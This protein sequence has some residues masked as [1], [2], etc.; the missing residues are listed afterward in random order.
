MADGWRTT[1]DMPEA[2]QKLL[3]QIKDRHRA[4]DQRRRPFIDRCN[5]YYGLYRNYRK[6]LAEPDRDLSEAKRDWGAELF[7]PYCFAT[8]ETI[9][10]RILASNPQMKVKPKD[11]QALS[12]VDSIA[13]LF[14]QRQAEI[15]YAMQLQPVVRSGLKYGLGVGKTMWDR[16]A[17][18]V[19][20]NAP[21]ALGYW[22]GMREVEETVTKSE[23]PT[24]EY[25][26]IFDFFNDPNARDIDTSEFAIHRTWRSTQYVKERIESG[27]WGTAKA[28]D[29]GRATRALIDMEAIEG[30]GSSETRDNVY[31]DRMRAAGLK[32]VTDMGAGK[33]HEVWEYHDRERVVTVLDKTFIVQN[34][35]CYFHAELPFQIFRP[36]PQEG[37]FFGIGEIEPI[38][39][40]Q[41]ELNT[42][43]SQR[44]DNATLILQKAFMYTEGRLVDPNDLTI[45]PG[46][47]IAV[48][49]NP[50]D[51]IAPLDF[52]ELPNSSY[53]EE[54]ALKR[55][56]ERTT[57]VSDSVAGGDSTGSV[58]TAT[59]IQLVQSAAN[60]RIAQKTANLEA[61]L[62]NPAAGQ[63]I[64]LYQQF[65]FGDRTMTVEDAREPSGF[66]FE[67]IGPEQLS[68]RV[69]IVADA[70][71][72]EPEN[73]PQKRN[74]AMI[75]GNQMNGDPDID[76]RK[77]KTWLLGEFGIA[78]PETWLTPL[79]PTLD[80][81]VVGELLVSAGMDQDAALA[82][83]QQALQTSADGVQRPGDGGHPAEQV[84]GETPEQGS[85]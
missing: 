12:S 20:R 13:R 51:V 24:F 10:P 3:G 18:T 76:Q 41:Y 80:P 70:G 46:E 48:Y 21:R 72:T 59:G 73:L 19:R 63:W 1:A 28:L 16:E 82:L 85:A 38:A 8:I 45:A 17:K 50:R 66:R 43:R 67:S 53:S 78:H 44:R 26:D 55:D 29:T 32:D 15:K 39:H 37:E 36:T 69:E 31:A 49:G 68:Q 14:E 83:I 33:L 9:L 35:P 52:G 7:I 64:E 77:L 61:E 60:V 11:E 22:H 54:E 25:V 84:Q 42:L 74:D 40:L 75:V 2:E 62:I 4:S 23:G 34:K 56:I 27:A 79:Q 30:L 57:G 47:G 5:E 58:D 81:N 65:T 6:L 71:S